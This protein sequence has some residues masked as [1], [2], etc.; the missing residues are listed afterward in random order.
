MGWLGGFSIVALRRR[1]PGI[2]TPLLLGGLAYTAGAAVE[3]TPPPPLIPGV[4]RAHE[5][6]HLAVILGLSLHWRFIW[7]IA[8][9]TPNHPIS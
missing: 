3:W 5:V 7:S 2:V 8:D 1:V 9:V 4:I 6:F